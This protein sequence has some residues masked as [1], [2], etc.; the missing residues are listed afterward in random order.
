[1]NLAHTIKRS[2]AEKNLE[3]RAS[4]VSTK[5]TFSMGLSTLVPDGESSQETIVK[6]ADDALYKAKE[7]GRNQIRLS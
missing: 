1:M 6:K 3:H 7:A 2:I 4:A 5:V